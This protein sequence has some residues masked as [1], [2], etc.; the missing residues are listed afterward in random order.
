MTVLVNVTFKGAGGT[1]TAE[2]INNKGAT[3]SSGTTNKTGLITLT[4]VNTGD[5]ISI[6]GISSSLG[7]DVSID[8]HTSPPT[9]D[10]YIPGNIGALYIAQ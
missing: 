6:S 8:V 9:P 5:G 3:I 4:G 2:A 7:T 10:H 1:L